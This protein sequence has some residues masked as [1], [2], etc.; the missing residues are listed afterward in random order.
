MSGDPQHW[1]RLVAVAEDEVGAVM[2]ELPDSVRRK[3]AD[4]PVTFEPAPNEEMVAAGIHRER[5]LGLFTGVPYPKA[6]AV[7]Q[8]LPPQII[9]FLGN[10]WYYVRGDAEAFR[11][12]VRRTLLHE[13]GHFLGLD[14]RQVREKGL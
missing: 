2:E 13:I 12:Q 1:S 8:R 9:L 5:T 3:L 6:I 14:E 11:D 4:L 10:I 7:S